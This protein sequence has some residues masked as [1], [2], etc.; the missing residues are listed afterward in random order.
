MN[1]KYAVRSF[2]IIILIGG[3]F[4]LWVN[5]EST[6]PELTRKQLLLPECKHKNIIQEYCTDIF[7]NGNNTLISSLVKIL[8]KSDTQTRTMAYAAIIDWALE[9]KFSHAKDFI[10]YL[11]TQV[12][13]QPYQS[14][15]DLKIYILKKALSTHS[16][17]VVTLLLPH[18]SLSVLITKDQ[19]GKSFL[20]YAIE[21]ENNEGMQ[22]ISNRIS[23]LNTANEIS[24]SRYFIYGSIGVIATGILLI[25]AKWV[26]A[27]ALFSVAARS[28]AH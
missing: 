25:G 19:N 6:P 10:Q 2:Y 14:E 8:R 16:N 26:L 9:N 3:S 1:F 11:P 13:S 5:T 22:L 4:P 27:Q 28:M 21:V 18:F 24:I 7:I 23:F 15:D 20:D 12:L 17:D